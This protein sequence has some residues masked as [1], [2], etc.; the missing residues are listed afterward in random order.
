MLC[1]ESN[2]C[3]LYR[4]RRGEGLTSNY[5]LC[6]KHFMPE[7][8]E[9]DA[10]CYR[11][12]VG[13]PAKKCLKQGA[14]PTIFSK[15]AAA[16]YLH[17]PNDQWKWKSVSSS[18]HY[19]APQNTVDIFIQIVYD[20]LLASLT[21]LHG[22]PMLRYSTTEQLESATS[23]QWEPAILESHEELELQLESATTGYLH[24][25]K[26]RCTYKIKV[27]PIISRYATWIEK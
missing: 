14:I 4:T 26:F 9:T 1:Q 6:A 25:W 21:E 19:T 23:E 7:C 5:L 12:A 10:S 11:D 17:H 8:F 2:G 22:T 18:E 15:L 24:K 3:E 16:S 13:I 20:I 27:S